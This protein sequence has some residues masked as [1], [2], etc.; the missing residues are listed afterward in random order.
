MSAESII[1]AV[2]ALAGAWLIKD[3][4]LGMLFRWKSAKVSE[5][6]KKQKEITDESVTR[7]TVARESFVERLRKYRSGQN[8]DD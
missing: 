7:A 5:E 2:V 3:G 8:I 1:V 4:I 6:V